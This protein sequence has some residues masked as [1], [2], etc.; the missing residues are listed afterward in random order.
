MKFQIFAFSIVMMA[1]ASGHCRKQIA[2]PALPAV[3]EKTEEVENR[4][5]VAKPDGSLQ[6]G[7]GKIISLDTMKSQLKMIQIFSQAKK[8]DGLMHIQVCGS[9]TGTSN[10]YEISPKDLKEA[11]KYG[12]K[13]WLF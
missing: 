10:V 5:F 6:C 7:K 3:E 9:A 2:P 13:K 12:F 1:C 8:Q 11:E 4:V